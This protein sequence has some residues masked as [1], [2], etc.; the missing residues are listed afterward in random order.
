MHQIIR[1]AERVGLG[2][3]SLCICLIMLIAAGDTAMRYVLNRPWPW[4]F[5]VTSNYLLVGAA[6]LGIASTFTMGD[7]INIDMLHRRLPA[8]LRARIDALLALVFLA[9][10]GLIG[11]LALRASIDAAVNRDFI[12]GYFQWPVW[13]SYA[14]IPIG[15]AILCLRLSHHIT[16][17]LKDGSDKFVSG[18]HIED[19]AE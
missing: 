16:L 14:P 12:P 8:N 13:L 4:A 9:L 2:L 3:A 15:T 11:S 17:L 1:R 5:E 10:F 18:A 19:G 6:Y 7:H